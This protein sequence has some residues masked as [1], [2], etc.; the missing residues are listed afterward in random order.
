MVSGMEVQMK[1]RCGN[2]FLHVEKTA[3]DDIHQCLLKIYGD[4]R[5]DVSTVRWWVVHF[6]SGDGATKAKPHYR[7][8]CTTVTSQNEEH[9]DLLFPANWLMVMMMLK[10]RVL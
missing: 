8:P 4:Q 3:H 1:Q 7:W 6:S 9:L 5:V 10:N 2:E